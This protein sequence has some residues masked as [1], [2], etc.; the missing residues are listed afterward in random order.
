MGDDCSRKWSRSGR[1]RPRLPDLC[2]T[3][4]PWIQ[5]FSPRGGDV[6]G[7]RMKVSAFA[8]VGYRTFPDDFEQHHD[9]SVDTP[10]RAGRSAR[11][12]RGVSRLPRR[13]DARG[14]FGLRRGGLHRARAGQLRHE[15]QPEPDGRG[16]GLRH[17]ERRAR[18]RHLSRP[19][20]RSASRASR[21]ASPR[22]TR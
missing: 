6:K 18:R 12:P 4:W 9:S 21:C 7:D 14:P 8:Q 22:S 5:R 19:A 2:V 15:R 17:R 13:P 10:W 20:D 3:M 11:S 1:V 16:A